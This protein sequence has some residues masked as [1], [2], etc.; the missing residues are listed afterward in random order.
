MGV[1]LLLPKVGGGAKATNRSYS[2]DALEAIVAV[3]EAEL[4][5]LDLFVCAV[6]LPPVFVVQRLHAKVPAR[7]TYSWR[8]LPGL[9]ATSQR[10]DQVGWW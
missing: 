4:Q 8:R 7:R 1:D 10:G 2:A 9:V 3:L 6:G 5:P